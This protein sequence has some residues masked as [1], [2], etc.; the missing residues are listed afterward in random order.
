M[1][2]APARYG[3]LIFSAIIT[4][5]GLQIENGDF[6]ESKPVLLDEEVSR[7][8]CEGQSLGFGESRF[9]VG[10]VKKLTGMSFGCAS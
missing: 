10:E 8:Y 3:C 9:P 7:W 2:F 5:S 4:Q 1:L 6:L